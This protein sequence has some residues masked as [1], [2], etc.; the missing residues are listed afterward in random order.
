MPRRLILFMA[1]TALLVAAAVWLADRPGQV[2]LHWQGWRVDTSV[3]VLVVALLAILAVADGV[4]RLVQA[5]LRAPGRL[6]AGRRARRT[7]DGYRALSDGLAAVA[8]GDRRAAHKLA[9]R[10]DKL[11]ADP[12]LTGL[13]AAR[14][15]ELGGKPA[16]AETRFLALVERPQTAFLGLQGLMTLALDRGDREAALG[17]ARRAWATN[18]AAEGLAASL[19]D[20]QARAGQ[21]AEAELTLAE[22]AKR[23][24]LAGPELAHRRALVLTQRAQDLAAA[25]PAEAARLALAARRADPRF[26]PAAVL[27]AT[28]LHR[29]G[30]PR[31]AAQVVEAAWRAAAHADL[32]AAWHSLAPAETPLARV[33]RWQRLVRANPDAALGHAALGE[34]AL[35][36]KLW[37]QA[38]THLDLAAQSQPSAA[39]Y[40]LLAR[41][42]REEAGNDPAA[43]SWIAKAAAA[44]PDPAWTCGSCG[45]RSDAWAALC[46]KCG[47]VDGLVWR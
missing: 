5:V 32:A 34:A 9:Q 46:A 15:A 42:E 45:A 19:F 7:R 43:Q 8:T 41:L 18:P 10:A 47:T 33:K 3:P 39:T 14:A 20:L 27:A 6:L 37:G 12:A 24:A 17:F 11:L 35:A 13:L 25:D 23:D 44:P 29:L 26:T 31:K 38:R 40:L 22:A 28:L 16:E 4:R 36:A 1:V 21:W 2:V 30:K